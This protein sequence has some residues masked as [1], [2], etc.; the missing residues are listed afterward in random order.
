MYNRKWDSV[1]DGNVWGSHQSWLK[2]IKYNFTKALQVPE[3]QAQSNLFH[4]WRPIPASD[5]HMKGMR[6]LS[7][8]NTGPLSVT[9]S[10]LNKN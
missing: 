3:E 10:Q 7:Y 4:I 8:I 2:Y 5:I 1:S 9:I 6:K